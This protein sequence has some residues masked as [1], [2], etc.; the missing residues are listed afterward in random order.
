MTRAIRTRRTKPKPTDSAFVFPPRRD[1][2][3]A[4]AAASAHLDSWRTAL[5]DWVAQL[6]SREAPV[7]AGNMILAFVQEKLPASTTPA[8]VCRRDGQFPSLGTWMGSRGG[9][10]QPSVINQAHHFFEWYLD[11]KLSA[12]D[13][14]GRLVRSPEHWNPLALRKTPPR[15]GETNKDALPTAYVRALRELLMEKDW[16]WAK[17]FSQDYVEVTDALTGKRERVWCPVRACVIALKLFLPLRTFQIRMLDSGEG[18]ARVYEKGNWVPNTGPHAPPSGSVVQNGFLRPFTDP[19]TGEIIT[20][21]RPNTNKTA[22]L[23]ADERDHGYDIPWQHEEVIAIVDMVRQWQA[24]YNPVKG[25]TP[26]SEVRR[27][28]VRLSGVARSGSVFFLMREPRGRYVND[29]IDRQR[30]DQMWGRLLYALQCRLAKAGRTNPNGEPIVL[31]TLHAGRRIRAEYGLHSLR[32][33]LLTALATEGEVPLHILSKIVA[34]HTSMVMTLYYL[35][36]NPSGINRTLTEAHL[37]VDREACDLFVASLSSD[38]RDEHAIVSNSDAGLA[39]L[40]RSNSGM[41]TTMDTGV[42]PVGG[43][44]CGDGGPRL[45]KGRHAEVPGGQCVNCRFH[46]TGPAFL[47]Q[48]T[49]RFQTAAMA[50][51]SAIRHHRLAEAAARDADSR[52]LAREREGYRGPALEVD[53]AY[54]RVGEV[55]KRIAVLATTVAAAGRL[56]DRCIDAARR[57]PGLN[58]VLA[59]T[60]G[61][62]VAAVREATELELWDAVCQHAHVHPCPEVDEAMAKRN[63]AI[64]HML[65]RHGKASVLWKLPPDLEAS[66]TN[67]MMRWHRA[68]HGADVTFALLGGKTEGLLNPNALVENIAKRLE[69]AAAAACSALERPAGQASAAEAAPRRPS[70]LVGRPKKNPTRRLA[71]P[72]TGKVPRDSAA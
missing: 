39:S 71:P 54:H 36:P 6:A 48:L 21:M 12:P 13:D 18:D 62:I 20:G 67:E 47:P 22:D 61:D 7:R 17:G 8:D 65:A 56:V 16:A 31:A 34:G 9:I 59:G 10:T 49:A 3:F 55:E 32:V 25:P 40:S 33:S 26:W 46:I 44:R 70:A 4:W 41:W 63:R 27:P 64:E 45:P 23:E 72:S 1:P 38:T 43:T 69:D 29:P 58:L 19:H 53:Q 28:E 14:Y 66:V 24:R 50:L 2:A 68:E 42:C 57:T 30:V 35:K 51:N 60:E 11:T 15:R 5:R 37:K 52:Q